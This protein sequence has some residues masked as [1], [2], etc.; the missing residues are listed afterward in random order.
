MAAFITALTAAV[1]IPAIVTMQQT[2][3]TAAIIIPLGFLAY[4]LVKK[5]FMRAK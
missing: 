1:D 3:L 5:T 2:M 4:G